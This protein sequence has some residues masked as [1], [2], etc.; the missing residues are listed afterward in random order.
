MNPMR[1]F[2]PHGRRRTRVIGR[3]GGGWE[4]AQT[5]ISINKTLVAAAN[6]TLPNTIDVHLFSQYGLA[7]TGRDSANA[8]TSTPVIDASVK[9][10]SVKWAKFWVT[11]GFTPIIAN[12]PPFVIV[13]SAQHWAHCVH[14]DEIGQADV[15]DDNQILLPSHNGL[16]LFTTQVGGVGFLGSNMATGIAG[17]AFTELFSFPERILHRD[18][19]IHQFYE[20]SG[21]APTDASASLFASTENFTRRKFGI[22]KVFLKDADA[23]WYHWQCGGGFPQD[24]QV[25]ALQIAA[26]WCYKVRK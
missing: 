26:L 23:L 13:D 21:G 14:K 6:L 5:F 1:R 9:G 7:R 3:L 17:G 25:M 12:D 10:V 20:I 16:N 22:K 8:I 19:G 2:R 15:I 18:F 24:T 4:I 11:F